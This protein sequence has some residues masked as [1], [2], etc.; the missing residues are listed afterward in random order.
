MLA[1]MACGEEKPPPQPRSGPPNVVLILSDDQ[2]YGDYGFMGSSIARTPNIDALAEQGTVFPVAY[3]TASICRPSQLSLLTGLDPLQWE[4]TLHELREQGPEYRGVDRISSFATLPR[5]LS[6]HGFESLQ[7]G[8]LWEGD[9][10]QAGFA[11]GQKRRIAAG[12]EHLRAWSGGARSHAVGRT[13]MQ[14][15]YEFIDKHAHRRFF[16]WFAPM[17]PHVPFDAT[18]RYTR[19][20]EKLDLPPDAV[21]YYANIERLDRAVGELVA[22]LEL[23]ELRQDTLIV[24]LADNGWEVEHGPSR[25]PGASSWKGGLRGKSSMYELGWRTP[26]IFN[27][28]GRVPAGVRHDTLASS[29]DVFQTVLDYSGMLPL[30]GRPGLSLRP[31][32][33]GGNPSLRDA[34]IGSDLGIRPRTAREET[35]EPGP[36]PPAYFVR[37]AS[38]H[39][40]WNS[41]S[42]VEELYAVVEDPL[43]QR[44]V[45]AAH[46]DRARA[47]RERISQWI[48]RMS[49]PVTPIPP[50]SSKPRRSDAPASPEPARTGA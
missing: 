47:Y 4:S 41:E 21:G 8:K 50:M 39:F 29:L 49:E 1:A 15:V 16:V 28:P 14:P 48:D 12:V 37:D 33:E 17:L 30:A 44:N 38:W 11:A 26:L 20:Y 35:D 18:E 34:L 6:L 22:H 25:A 45:V 13:T 46:P 42:D 36:R 2:A 7:A 32:I 3:N 19:R 24:F 5:V 9:Y 43:E 10:Q 40:I 31:V 27:S 23:R